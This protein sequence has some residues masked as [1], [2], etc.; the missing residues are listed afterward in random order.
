MRRNAVYRKP[1]ESLTLAEPVG[2]ANKVR[3]SR[4]ES[5]RAI[6]DTAAQSRKF[7]GHLIVYLEA[8]V[9]LAQLRA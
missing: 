9:L 6:S 3:S 4:K 7:V 1:S 8:G 5:E 2:R